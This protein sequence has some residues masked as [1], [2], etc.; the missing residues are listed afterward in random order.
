MKRLHQREQGSNI[1]PASIKTS[2]ALAF[3]PISIKI[4]L[5]SSLLAIVHRSDGIFAIVNPSL[6][7][8]IPGLVPR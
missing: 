6:P 3:K 4:S 2:A 5:Q 8:R 1:K 7:H